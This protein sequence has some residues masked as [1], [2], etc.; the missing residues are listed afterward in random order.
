MLR[1]IWT[2]LMR[3]GGHPKRNA[4]TRL[5]GVSFAVQL[6]TTSQYI[7][8]RARVLNCSYDSRPRQPTYLRFVHL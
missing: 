2:R 8:S 1:R 4:V 3:F 7:A 6:L 5:R